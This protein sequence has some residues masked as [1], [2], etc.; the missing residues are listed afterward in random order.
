VAA[1]FEPLKLAATLR[2]F[3][4][5]LEIDSLAYLHT[6]IVAVRRRGEQDIDRQ[7]HCLDTVA[8]PSAQLAV[9][10]FERMARAAP[11]GLRYWS[12]ISTRLSSRLLSV[13][14]RKQASIAC[15]LAGANRFTA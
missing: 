2:R 4:E 10:L 1:L 7:Q 11:H 8:R 3:L 15:F 9:A 5:L 12:C 13:S 14:T 6:H